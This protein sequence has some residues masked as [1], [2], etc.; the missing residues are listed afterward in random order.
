MPYLKSLAKCL[1]PLVL[2][3]LEAD[4]PG[5]QFIVYAAIQINESVIF[6]FHRLWPDEPPYYGE[7][8]DP[9]EDRDL[10]I[11]SARSGRSAAEEKRA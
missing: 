7:S 9:P 11:V 5:K 4:F 3:R 6:R 2:G 1:C 10:I 8:G